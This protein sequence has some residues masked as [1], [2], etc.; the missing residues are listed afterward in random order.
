[1]MSA[2]GGKADVYVQ[3]DD[4]AKSAV[5]LWPLADRSLNADNVRD[6]GTADIAIDGAMSAFDPKRT[7]RP[8][9][10]SRSWRRAMPARN[11]VDVV[12]NRTR[13]YRWMR[14][15]T[16]VASI[17]DFE[18]VGFRQRRTDFLHQAPSRLT[19]PPATNK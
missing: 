11:G 8:S 12:P 5:S 9:G 16:H 6:W 18:I 1:L 10:D 7:S 2:I 4:P 3:T 14:E 13:H 19:G 17:S 15:R